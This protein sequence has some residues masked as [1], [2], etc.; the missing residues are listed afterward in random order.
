MSMEDPQSLR[1]LKVESV[2]RS[3]N[4]SGLVWAVGVDALRSFAMTLRSTRDDLELGITAEVVTY[5][6]LHDA[7][8]DKYDSEQS[9][10]PFVRPTAAYLTLQPCAEG[11]GLRT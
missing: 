4:W 2:L 5:F 6:G 8:S 7:N 3:D 10:R 1:S 11:A 9:G